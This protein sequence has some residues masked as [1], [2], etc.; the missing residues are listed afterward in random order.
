MGGGVGVL[1][2]ECVAERKVGKEEEARR[3]AVWGD[4]LCST[5]VGRERVEMEVEKAR[6]RGRERRNLNL[7]S[8][9]EGVEVIELG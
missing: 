5:A 6:E 3:F 9:D 7:R 8:V 2:C 4:E 1:G